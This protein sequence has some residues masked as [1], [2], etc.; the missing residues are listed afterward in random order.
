MMR[1]SWSHPGEGRESGGRGSAGP[2]SQGGENQLDLR[3]K[4]E[5]VNCTSESG[6]RGSAGPQSQ[7]WRQTVVVLKIYTTC[8]EYISFLVV[9]ST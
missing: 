6:G 1:A 7:T 5:R 2:E 8:V 3:V 4:G 9:S